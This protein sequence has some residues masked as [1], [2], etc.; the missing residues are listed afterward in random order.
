MMGGGGSVGFAGSQSGG[1]PIGGE[2]ST[3]NASSANSAA[4][5]GAPQAFKLIHPVS[6]PK[7]T[8]VFGQKKSSYSG[9]IVW[10][11][12]HKG[13]DYAAKQGDPIYAA[14]DGEVI[15]T[16][17]GGELGNYV[18]IKHAN[19]MYTF[20]AHLSSKSVSQ[21]TV[22]QGQPIGSAG[23]T[24][25]KSFGV[26]LHF[27]LS[28]SGTTAGAIDPA[29]YMSVSASSLGVTASNPEQSSSGATPAASGETA[30]GGS[31]EDTS[32]RTLSSATNILEITSS[33][34]KASSGATGVSSVDALSAASFVSAKT[35][36][37]QAANR[38]NEGGEGYTGDEGDSVYVS[39]TG[40]SRILR[41]A[42]AKSSAGQV[43]TNNVTINLTIAQ[44]TD[45]EARRFA[46][47]VKRT[48]EEDSMMTRMART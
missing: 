1:A 15:P 47:M 38:P 36:A 7:I 32:G 3:S 12:G 17:S 21:G 43:S 22:K 23:N 37:S 42:K 26:H 5:A 44:A 45:D 2:T 6:S 24:G 10:P 19:G 20:Y 13:V 4:A 34:Y 48:L 46:V 30:T 14:A 28:T 39:P 16:D 41:G 35:G 25:T 31:G 27:A 18:K 29:P 8:A 33:G 40:A 9:E 11:N